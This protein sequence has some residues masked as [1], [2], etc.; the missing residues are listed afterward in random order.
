[1]HI[2]N[3]SIPTSRNPGEKVCPL[4]CFSEMEMAGGSML[5][6]ETVIVPSSI[7]PITKG[8]ISRHTMFPTITT[9]CE[10]QR[11]RLTRRLPV[12]SEEIRLCA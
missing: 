12:Y 4:P 3:I 1:L 5:G 2:E 11:R 7:A 8:H 6:Q 9:K 10:Y